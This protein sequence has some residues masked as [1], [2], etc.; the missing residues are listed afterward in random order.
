[1]ALIERVGVVM[2]QHCEDPAD[3]AATLERLGFGH[4]VVDPTIAVLLAL[5]AT[6]SL[7]VVTRDDRGDRILDGLPAATARRLNAS[8]RYPD[9]DITAADIDD[10][11]TL[12]HRLSRAAN[13]SPSHRV[14]VR[15]PA[16][17]HR[18]MLL[19]LAL[20]VVTDGHAF[21][22]GPRRTADDLE[23]G[24]IIDLGSV[25]ATEDDM[26]AFAQ[27]WDPL[28]FHLDRPRAE[29]S[30]LGM[31][32][33]SGVYT[34]AMIQSMTARTMLRNFA[35]VAGRGSTG[36]RLFRPVTPGMTLH[37]T[38]EV[39]AVEPRSEAQSLVT[40]TSRLDSDGDRIMEQTGQL[41]ALRS[42][43]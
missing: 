32:C 3:Y 42:A 40:I 24:Q 11:A 20:D 16:D 6:R 4:V 17:G 25:T 28:D 1:M 18:G 13:T 35:I 31:L 2:P 10:P 26:V 5:G 21:R 12:R 34:Q 19:T 30:P 38:V 43:T 29:R 39:V 23:I 7:T 15:L 36:L 8:S 27:R 9:V 41:V 37:G 22:Q 14:T 33:A